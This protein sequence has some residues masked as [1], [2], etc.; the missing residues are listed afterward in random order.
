[1]KWINQ[2]IRS[3]FMMTSKSHVTCVT[4]FLCNCLKMNKISN[5][6]SNKIGTKTKTHVTFST[7]SKCIYLFFNY[8]FFSK[9]EYWVDRSKPAAASDFWRFSH[10]VVLERHLRRLSAAALIPCPRICFPF[11]PYSLP[12]PPSFSPSLS[13]SVS[14]SCPLPVRPRPREG[15]WPVTARAGKC[16]SEQRSMW[17]E[18]VEDAWLPFFQQLIASHAALQ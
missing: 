9:G 18:D 4:P 12:P 8:N 11:L 7:Y 10:L 6:I 1:M 16:V 3:Y 17:G 14:P 13:L 5:K 15:R 2:S